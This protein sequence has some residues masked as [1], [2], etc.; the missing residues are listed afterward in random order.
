MI[1]QHNSLAEKFLKK[2]FWLYLFSFIVAPIWYLVKVIVSYNLTVSEV[3]IIY[4]VISIIV[5]LTAYN[6]FWM[7]ES[8]LYFVPK[9]VTEKRYDK[10]KT[11]LAYGFAVQMITSVILTL[12]FFFWADIIWKYYFDDPNAVGVLKV[13]SLFFI[14]VNIFELTTNFF[15]AV[16]DTFFS[17]LSELIRMSAIFISVLSIYL[18][19]T[20]TII[21]FSKAWIIWL[22]IGISFSALI[23]YFKYYKKYLSKEKIFFNFWFFKEIAKYWI[24]VVLSAQVWTLLSQ[25]DMQMILFMLWTNS[26][27]YYTNYLSIISIAFMIIWPIFAFLFPLFTELASKQEHKKIKLIKTELFSVFLNIIIPYSLFFFIFWQ[28]IT[29]LFFW[30]KFLESWKILQYSIFFLIFNFLLQVNFNILWAIGKIKERVK[31]LW[32]A[33]IFNIITNY[34]FLKMIWVY[35]WWIASW[36]WWI[37]IYFMSEKALRWE[38]KAVLDKKKVWITIFIFWLLWLFSYLV[39]PQNIIFRNKKGQ[40]LFLILSI[41]LWGSIFFLREKSYI[42]KVIL[43]IKSIKS[44]K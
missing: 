36:I 3:G 19:D 34:I 33:I 18:L 26:A 40:I 13:F 8:I 32:Y 22:Y 27:W 21:S 6:E 41:L 20:R 35:W 30:I 38:Y 1:E 15:Q 14:W 7:T 29:T 39:M 16:Q 5:L 43:Q 31:I 17:K 12:F 37:F 11:L 2:W 23:F 44:V 4:W 28:L 24:M 25:I 10:I 42:A 9:F